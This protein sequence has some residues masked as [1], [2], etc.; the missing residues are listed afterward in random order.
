MPL[1][2]SVPRRLASTIV[3]QSL[4]SSKLQLRIGHIR[5]QRGAHL[6]GFGTL[7]FGAI[8]VGL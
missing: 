6:V 2:L 1:V 8:D 7:P 5:T 4:L 3:C